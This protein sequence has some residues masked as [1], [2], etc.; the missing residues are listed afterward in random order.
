[1]RQITRNNVTNRFLPIPESVAK[2]LESEPKISDFNFIKELGSGSFGRVLLVTHKITQAKYAI[3]AIDKRNKV[4][5]IEK[6]YFRREIEIMYRVHH[7]NVVKLYGHFEDN[8]YC[9]FIMEYMS[10]GN[11]YNLTPKGSNTRL[12]P[13]MITSIMKDVICATYFLHHMNPPIIH[14]DI[15]PENI[16][17]DEGLKAKLTDFGWSNY[18]EGDFKRLTVCGT[19]IYLAPEIIN[20]QGHDEKVDIWCIG[21]LLFELI[22][23]HVPFQGN[24]V[25][26]VKYNIRNMRIAWPKSMDRD[27]A[28]L[29]S[30]ILKYN[31]EERISLKQILLHPYFTKYIPNAYMS[32][33]KPDNNTQYRIFLVSK[34][35]PLTW[36][37]VFSGNN[38]DLRLKPFYGGTFQ[39]NYYSAPQQNNYIQKPLTQ[40]VYNQANY[41]NLLQKYDNLQREYY[42]LRKVG[43]STTALDSLRKELQEKENRINQ[44]IRGTDI[45]Y[46]IK[47]YQ[48]TSTYNDLKNENNEL[49]NNLNLYESQIKEQTPIMLDNN[50]NVIRNS[51]RTNNKNNFNQAMGQLRINLDDITQR[52]YNAIIMVKDREL[53][54][55]KEE[56]RIRREQEK[57]QFSALIN[58]YDQNLNSREKENQELKLRLQELQ[59]YFM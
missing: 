19:P 1:M 11:I 33:I 56:E 24:T 12:S 47:K 37:H 39:E 10:R 40:P 4:N 38:Y 26:T 30:R 20:E 58:V 59:N 15:K 6:P 45:G 17:L 50:F 57:Q 3:K 28:D 25:E 18:M 52:N 29:V 41:N 55:W 49:K 8:N 23:G 34:D 35:N 51:I 14:R 7:P 9:Y 54:R 31:P 42:E 22:T 5:I 13:Q 43:F 27:G 16:L 44:L 53:E 21:V 36:N 46:G 2:G 32:L 48:L